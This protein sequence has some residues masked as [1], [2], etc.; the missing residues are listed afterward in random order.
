M[1]IEAK[2]PTWTIMA[3]A[4]IKLNPLGICV[5]MLTVLIV[6][7]YM[8]SGPDKIKLKKVDLKQL[9][10]ASIESARRGGDEVVAV[11]KLHNLHEFVKGK[12]KE[13]A[14]EMRTDGD[15]RSQAAMTYGIKM[16]FPRI[17]V[18]LL[19]TEF[20]SVQIKQLLRI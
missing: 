20:Q 14:K 2:L 13:G 18:H 17:K 12:T 19:A 5:I 3:A 15:L 4:N 16:L 10:S 7:F 11:H 8:T 6:L 1:K 9:L